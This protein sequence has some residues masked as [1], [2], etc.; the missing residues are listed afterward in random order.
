LALVV[1]AGDFAWSVSA[2]ILGQLASLGFILAILWRALGWAMVPSRWAGARA[3][4]P[5]AALTAATELARPRSGV[6]APVESL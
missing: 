6:A 3:G 5:S 1:L 4:K 2:I